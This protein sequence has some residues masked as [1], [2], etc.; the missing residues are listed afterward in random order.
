[1]IR[2]NTLAVELINDNMY[3]L[4]FTYG[5]FNKT[6]LSAPFT[7]K[8]T[9]N[10]YNIHEIPSTGFSLNGT[11]HKFSANGFITFDFTSRESYI[12]I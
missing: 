2:S 3:R 5:V 8:R 4:N 12:Y 9:E 6:G 1:M 11:E 10:G 7:I